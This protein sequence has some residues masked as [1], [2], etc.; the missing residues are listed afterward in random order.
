MRVFHQNESCLA[1]PHPPSSYE[2]WREQAG[3]SHFDGKTLILIGHY[4]ST[5]W[6][7]T[8]LPVQ[9]IGSSTYILHHATLI[10]GCLE[11]EECNSMKTK[12]R[13]CRWWTFIWWHICC[14]FFFPPKESLFLH[15]VTFFICATH[16]KVLAVP[17]FSILVPNTNLQCRKIKF[18]FNWSNW[19]YLH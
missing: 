3:S 17:G 19:L 7:D 6:K 11:G 13:K 2:G 5:V 8:R 15:F 1:C 16:F 18:S 10:N 9:K 12:E 14:G 4:G